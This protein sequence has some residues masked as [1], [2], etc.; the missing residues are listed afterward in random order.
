MSGADAPFIV[1]LLGLRTDGLGPSAGVGEDVVVADQ[2]RQASGPPGQQLRESGRVC[3]REVD[4]AIARVPEMQHGVAAAQVG[5]LLFP[6]G[7]DIAELG[8]LIVNNGIRHN[9]TLTTKFA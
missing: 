6:L 4:A 8:E 7:E 2:T 5:S 9:S 1:E 3:S